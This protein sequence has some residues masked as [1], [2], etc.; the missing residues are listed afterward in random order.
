VEHP[1]VR[2]VISEH[3]PAESLELLAADDVDL[4][5]TYDYNLAPRTFERTF[6][7]RSLW[8]VPWSLGIPACSVGSDPPAGS[9]TE[10][11]E[12]FRDEDWIVNSRN[13]A[14][15]DAVGTIAA[16]A[17]FA[18]RVVHRADSLDLVQ[19]LV[20]GGYGVGL[21]PSDQPVRDGVDLVALRDPS[22]NLRAYACTRR[23][24]DD[25]PPL[26]LV[27]RLLAPTAR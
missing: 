25:W 14:D 12:R 4:A 17:G 13:T 10:V 11:F 18:P 24:R 16:L 2:L 5:L 6:R 15:E 8:E 19:D 1:G 9:A 7:A 22:V 3:E 21:L 20:A 27:L 26:A 23:G